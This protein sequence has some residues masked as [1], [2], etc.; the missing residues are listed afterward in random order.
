MKLKGLAKPMSKSRPRNDMDAHQNPYLLRGTTLGY[1]V[2]YPGVAA[3][4]DHSPPQPRVARGSNYIF[5]RGRLNRALHRFVKRAARKS[6]RK[7]KLLIHLASHMISPMSSTRSHKV[8]SRA[9]IHATFNEEH[10]TTASR[11]RCIKHSMLKT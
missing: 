9:Y 10:A 6:K 8:L 1:R 5:S 4:V 7:K 3:S 11:Y 2:W